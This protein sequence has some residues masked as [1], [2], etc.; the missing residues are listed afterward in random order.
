MN[1]LIPNSKL[2]TKFVILLLSCIDQQAHAKMNWKNFLRNLNLD[3][4]VQKIP[5]C[6]TN[7]ND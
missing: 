7:F 1:T 2:E 3:N 6:G 5:F 4:L